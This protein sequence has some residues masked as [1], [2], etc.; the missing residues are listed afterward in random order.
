VI[1][2]ASITS[3]ARGADPSE[4]PLPPRTNSVAAPE[5]SAPA[6]TIWQDGIGS[7]F[8]AS[9]QSV[10]VESG[11][12]PGMAAFGSRQAHDLALLDA[13]YGHMLSGVIG[14]DHWYRGNLEGRLELFGGMQFHPD[15]HADGWLIGL[16]PHLRYNLATGTRWIPFLD[17]GAGVT[18]VGTGLGAPDLSGTFQFN[19]QAATGMHW[20]FRDDLALTGE[21]RFM[22]L[23]CAG[24]DHP[25]LGANNVVCM[26]GVTWFFGK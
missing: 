22:H 18:A 19:L 12:A 14:P 20:F 2:L 24:I 1:I 26:V 15:V 8:L 4:Q 5:L 13:S 7:G 3:L 6:S 16:T 10:T 21:V 23:S 9:A 11:V 17:G 25:N